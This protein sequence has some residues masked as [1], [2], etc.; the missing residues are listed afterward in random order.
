VKLLILVVDDE[1]EFG[2]L[3]AINFGATFGLTGSDGFKS[4]GDRGPTPPRRTGG[5][6]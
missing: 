5:S 4:L 1:A 2:V 6:C 3:F